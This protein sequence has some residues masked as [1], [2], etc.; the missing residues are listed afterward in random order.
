MRG[1]IAIS[2]ATIVALGATAAGIFLIVLAFK[3]PPNGARFRVRDLF[4]D[5]DLLEKSRVQLIIE[6]CVGV[7]LGL[8]LSAVLLVGAVRHVFGS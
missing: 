1:V 5:I 6:G 8:A 7:S 3:M 4:R 2:V